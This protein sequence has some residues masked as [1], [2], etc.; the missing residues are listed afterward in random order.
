MPP[1][2]RWWATLLAAALWLVWIL[3][4]GY[5]AVTKERG[6]ILSR[7]QV[8]AATHAVV[9]D[10]DADEQGR[11]RSQFQVRQWLSPPP[12]PQPDR[13]EV[14]EL[15]RARGWTG[16]GPYLLLLEGPA[17]TSPESPQP[18]VFHLVGPQRVPGLDRAGPEPTIYP[19]T[20]SIRR[21]WERRQQW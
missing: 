14:P 17:P 6:P 19:W 3:W 20:D 2:W 10:I 8:A 18:P 7:L 9:A 5:A 11:P 4:L 13:I 12:S 1:R 21:Q 16:P 15:L